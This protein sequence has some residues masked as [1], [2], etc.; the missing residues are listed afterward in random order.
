MIITVY[1]YANNPVEIE[2]PAETYEDIQYI[3]VHILS[4]D[5][6]G[7]I[8]MKNE[9]AIYFDSSN[10]RLKGYHDGSYT[11]V[12]T[13]MIKRWI[14]Y[15]PKKDGLT[16]SYARMSDFYEWTYEEEEEF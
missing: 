1:D 2:I 13:K 10:T 14:E 4:G 9:E 15:E 3:V 8:I 7:T 16:I 5:E 6:A 11:V 12:G